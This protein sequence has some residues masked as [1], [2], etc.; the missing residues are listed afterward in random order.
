MRVRYPNGVMC[1]LTQWY[2]VTTNTNMGALYRSSV[3]TLYHQVL[4]ALHEQI[5]S[6]GIRVGDRLPS[7]AELVQ[8]YG[9]SR[10]TARRALDELRRQGL[11]RR[12]PGRGT[13]LSSPRLRTNLAYLRSFTEEINSRGYEPGAR[14]VSRVVTTA[15]KEVA[16]K[17]EMGVG[18]EVLCVRRLRL[19]DGRPIFVCDSYLPAGRIPEL[20]Q[21]DYSIVSL[22]ELFHEITGQKVDRAYQWI[23][24]AAATADVATLLE[25]EQGAPVLKVER[26]TFVSGDVPIESVIAFFH[27]GRYQHYNELSSRP[28]EV[29]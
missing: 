5:E 28:G 4:A 13:F 26:V 20:K 21:A 22:T 15:G 12:E 25:L 11:V 19:A 16:A 8:D 23:G 6:G 29:G 24:A 27:P 17:L 1:Y 2:I 14:V 10:T 7:E 18:E 3:G 9:V